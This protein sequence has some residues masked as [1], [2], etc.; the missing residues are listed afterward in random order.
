LFSDGS[1]WLSLARTHSLIGFSRCVTI[2]HL[3]YDDGLWGFFWASNR[4]S[5]ILKFLPKAI[6]R[7][8]L[9][10][11]FPLYE[12]KSHYYFPSLYFV[13]RR[14]GIAFVTGGKIIGYFPSYSLPLGPIFCS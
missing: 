14:W 12:A 7:K 4:A 13:R 3:S 2:S 6:I 5:R 8:T 11:F 10:I 1:C 9:Y